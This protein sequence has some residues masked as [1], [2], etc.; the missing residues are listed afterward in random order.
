MLGKLEKALI[1]LFD[2]FPKKLD[3]RV[4]FIFWISSPLILLKILKGYFSSNK[5]SITKS[6]NNP[7]SHEFSKIPGDAK[8]LD[9]CLRYSGGTDSTLT[10]ATLAQQ[11][12][13]VHLLTFNT[14]F[15]IFTLGLVSSHPSNSEFNLRLLQ[16]K[17]GKAAFVHK[18][19]E[20]SELRDDVYFNDYQESAK[21][22]DFNRVNLCPACTLS[23]HIETI[24]YCLNNNI[25][26]V[27][28][29]ANIETGQFPW[30]TQTLA[31]LLEFRDFYKS[32]GLEYIINPNYYHENSD[33]ELNELGIIPD[34][35]IR[36]FYPYRKKTQQFCIPIHLQSIC[37]RLHGGID[38]SAAEVPLISKYFKTMLDKYS[39]YIE[40][41]TTIT[42]ANEI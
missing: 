34:Q 6:I 2:R 12:K 5:A 42:Q 41:K 35:N 16:K 33:N 39:A 26:Y 21:E 23:M 27:C 9:I 14:S 7:P 40:R 17:F 20:F 37:R 31:N 24:V 4:V 32:F 11:F 19:I 25:K 1:T 3:R 13:Q 30:Q 8:K 22:K 28:D 18:I 36:K 15:K 38:L 29:G 10:A